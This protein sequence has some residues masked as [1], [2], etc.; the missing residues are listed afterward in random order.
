M[1]TFVKLQIFFHRLFHFDHEPHEKGYGHVDTHLT[2][3]G[4]EE[5]KDASKHVQDVLERVVA[6]GEL[7][8]EELHTEAYDV[9][10]VALSLLRL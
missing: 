1:I 7:S 5:F 8:T 10:E 3:G 4:F 2:E 6:E 9:G